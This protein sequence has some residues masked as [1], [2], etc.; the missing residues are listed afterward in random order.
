M[1]KAKHVILVD[2]LRPQQYF[3]E[4][5]HYCQVNSAF[6]TVFLL[7]LKGNEMFYF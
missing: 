4:H 2:P 1:T 3:W 7:L 6:L 5:P